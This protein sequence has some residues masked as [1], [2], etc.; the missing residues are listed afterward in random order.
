MSAE[1]RNARN[2]LLVLRN[3]KI[4]NFAYAGKIIDDFSSAGYYFDRVSY[5]ALD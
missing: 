1:H 5:I 4:N 2:C 3:R